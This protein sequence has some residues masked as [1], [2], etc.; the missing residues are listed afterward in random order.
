VQAKDNSNPQ[1]ATLAIR[2]ELVELTPLHPCLNIFFFLDDL[3]GSC[4]LLRY[5]FF[6]FLDL[7][8]ILDYTLLLEKL[9]SSHLPSCPIRNVKYMVHLAGKV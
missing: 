9:A 7:K 5:D 1:D 4:F 8:I 3:P 2:E 6:F